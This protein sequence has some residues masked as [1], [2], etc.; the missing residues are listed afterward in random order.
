V[1]TKVGLERETMEEV[2][3][4]KF[5][6]SSCYFILEEY[7]HF[8]VTEGEDSLLSAQSVSQIHNA[9]EEAI[10]AVISFLSSVAVSEDA[11]KAVLMKQSI[12][13]ASVRVLAAWMAEETVSLQHESAKLLP[14][15]IA[16][17]YKHAIPSNLPFY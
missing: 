7:M 1:E 16:L 12:V 8:I 2:V 9:I 10:R 11:T 15:L 4:N 3:E 6:L 14:F 13:H 5:L 17:G